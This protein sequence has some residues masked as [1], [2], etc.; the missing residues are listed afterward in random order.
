MEKNMKHNIRICTYTYIIILGFPGGS[1][2]KNLPQRGNGNP[3]QYSCLDNPTERGAWWATAHKVVKSWTDVTKEL[4]PT[5]LNVIGI[6][7]SFP[8]ESSKMVL[9]ANTQIS[10]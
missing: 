7:F 9:T 8:R 5:D 3:L 2:V 4:S 6:L 1:L 10:Y